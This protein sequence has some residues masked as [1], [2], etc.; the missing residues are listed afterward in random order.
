MLVAVFTGEGQ[1]VKGPSLSD[2][3][4]SPTIHDPDGAQH[5]LGL[6]P[7]ALT[8]ERCDVIGA[9][10]TCCVV[11]N[12]CVSTD[13]RPSWRAVIEPLQTPY[14]WGPSFVN[15]KVSKDPPVLQRKTMRTSMFATS[16]WGPRIIFRWTTGTIVG[17]FVTMGAK[18]NECNRY[19]DF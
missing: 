16:Y 13:I 1:K 19:R 8:H 14:H 6:L 11:I 15:G 2:W 7:H 17:H 4:T 3:A 5:P 12:G 9:S 10:R 18:D